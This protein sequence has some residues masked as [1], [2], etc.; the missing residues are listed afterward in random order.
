MPLLPAYVELIHSKLLLVYGAAW[1]AAQGGIT[2]EVA[3]KHWAHELDG[4]SYEAIT[5]ALRNLP[6][7]QPPNVLQFRALCNSRPTPVQKLLPAPR[8]AMP[9][10]VKAKLQEARAAV[11]GG[12]RL[13]WAHSLRKREESG[14]RLSPYQREAWR[15]ALRV[16]QENQDAIG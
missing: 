11:T 1:K 14:E 9:P 4:V 16:K 15:H 7:N 3:R 13:S 2:A 6:P 8:T 10:A 5:H 12:N